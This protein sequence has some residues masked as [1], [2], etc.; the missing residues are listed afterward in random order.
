MNVNI[1]IVCRITNSDCKQIFRV[2]EGARMRTEKSECITET[3]LW[4]GSELADIYKF[5]WE[6]W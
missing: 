3:E 6:R 4:E 2:P 1:V 5:M